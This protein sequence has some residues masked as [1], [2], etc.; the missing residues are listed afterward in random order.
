[1]ESN[2]MSTCEIIPLS[3]SNC[4]M[5]RPTRHVRLGI[6]WSLVQF[7]LVTL[8][9]LLT[10]CL[11]TELFYQIFWNE[12]LW[13]SCFRDPLPWETILL[14]L[15]PCAIVLMIFIWPLLIFLAIWNRSF[16]RE[17]L[18]SL[19]L[20]GQKSQTPLPEIIRS[21]AETIP[22]FF[23]C[24]KLRK[25]AAALDSGLSFPESVA[26]FPRLLTPEAVLMIQ[27]TGDYPHTE[28][29]IDPISEKMKT[30]TEMFSVSRYA[31]LILLLWIYDLAIIFHVHLLA[32]NF[33]MIASDYN[34]K[35]SSVVNFT[36]FFLQRYFWMIQTVFVVLSILGF[37]GLFLKLNIF[38][39]R[40]WILRRAFHWGDA[41]HLLHFIGI[42]MKNS[43][44]LSRIL[45]VYARMQ[46]SR[47]RCRQTIKIQQAVESGSSWLNELKR[48]KIIDAKE[49]KL[50]ES[51]QKTGNLPFMINEIALVKKAR[52]VRND[53]LYSKLLFAFCTMSIGFFVGIFALSI[54]L[55]L[56]ELTKSLL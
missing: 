51:A 12:S 36:I 39:T 13:R 53:D 15:F 31:Y 23:Y 28:E 43:E 4:V 34:A 6:L 55:P 3:E 52:Q 41:G 9:A 1:M 33:Q 56:T 18:T 25:F 38:H 16:R 42:G 5:K 21:Y 14:V 2:K 29:K 47:F 40:P 20:N 10:A 45:D 19:L 7:L 24:R 44:S 22:S 48:Q 54:F 30:E 11:L 26:R 32:E 37:W 27:L 49:K 17:T 50:L 35:Y 46:V 8:L